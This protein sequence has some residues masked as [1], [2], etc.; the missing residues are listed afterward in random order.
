MVKKICP[1]MQE[2]Q[3]IQVQSLGWA[4]PLEEGKATHPGIL[5]WRIQWTKE[6]G[7]LQSIKIII[8]EN[9]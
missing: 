7:G 5:A 6:L 9:V 2:T 3:E 4:D 1:S 8:Q